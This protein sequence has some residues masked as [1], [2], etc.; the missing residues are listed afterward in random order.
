MEF[1]W[2]VVIIQYVALSYLHTLVLVF[3]VTLT[4]VAVQG[5]SGTRPKCDNAYGSSSL[6]TGDSLFLEE[7]QNYKSR[8]LHSDID[9]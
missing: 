4:G 9:V 1:D 6:P 8:V 7:S 5:S 3:T 2:V